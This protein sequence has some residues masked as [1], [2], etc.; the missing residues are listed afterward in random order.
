MFHIKKISFSNLI[1][2]KFAKDSL[3]LTIGTSIAQF[4]PFVIYPIISR[5]Y[6][7]EQFGF[8]AS[9]SAVVSILT[10][11]ATGKYEA[12]ILIADS[13]DNAA[14][15]FSLSVFL[16]IITMLI[17]FGIYFIFP[18]TIS[19]ISGNIGKWF[20]LCPFAAFLNSIFI[21]YNEWCV[22]LKRYKSLSVNKITNS[23]SINVSK[24]G[25]GYAPTQYGLV[26][27]T[28]IGRFITAVVCLFRVL[29][30]DW[31][32]FRKVTFDEIKKQAV[33]F[34]NFP[35][36]T[37]PAQLLN[38]IG[39]S[40]PIFII[41]NQYSSEQVGYFSMVMTLLNVPVNVISFSIKDVF[42]QKANEEYIKRGEFKDLFLRVFSI[43]TFFVIICCLC[44]IWFLPQLFAIFLGPQWEE[45]GVYS[46]LLLPMI[47][48]D[49]IAMSFSGVLVV[50]EKLKQN[51]YWQIYYVVISVLCLYIG[52][53]IWNSLI[54][55]LILF[56]IGRIS[57][58]II[59]IIM[60][61]RYSYFHK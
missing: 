18:K 24:L 55:T 48:V 13:D 14:N 44:V 53:L 49:F 27:G 47:G 7:P 36:F 28:V 54:N 41:A 46:Q 3:I 56:S 25:L 10:V 30:N 11:L 37:L 59:L 58:Y 52:H 4:F 38:A 34:I 5:I 2:S 45:A 60:C 39:I 16:S 26:Y 43:V 21:I 57:A 22:R 19:S 40:F 6:T 32:L 20:L 29:I 8:L 12:S 9:L 33:R 17:S 23:V 50:T 31:H 51:L 1:G 42:R 15:I 61:Y 35:K